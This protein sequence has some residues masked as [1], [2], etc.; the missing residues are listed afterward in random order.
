M[1]SVKG[2]SLEAYI[3]EGQFY[4]NDMELGQPYL[5][6]NALNIRKPIIRIANWNG[7]GPTATITEEPVERTVPSAPED[8]IP[9]LV[10]SLGVDI[11][12]GELL[13]SGGQFVLHN[14][15]KEPVRALPADQL[16]LKH[17]NLYDIQVEIDSFRLDRDTFSGRVNWIAAKDESGF[18]L[19]R[20]SAREAVVSP[21]EL[22][23]NGLSI[24]TPTTSLGDSLRFTYNGFDDWASFEDKV[25]MDA[26][27][28]DA[29]VTLQ[30][31]IA[32]VP[33]LN[34]NPFFN[35]NR[36]TNLQIE[37]RVRGK[38][39]NLR[40]NDLNITLAD[41]THL[42]GSFSSQNLAVPE[43][44]F[45]IL[46]LDQLN[47]RLG[48]LRQLIPNFNP[49][50]NFNKLGRL[51]FSGSFVGFFVD[52]VAKGQLQTDLGDAA[53]DMQMVLTEGAERARYSGNLNLTDFDL[54]GWSG[55]PDF[56]LVDFSSEVA[57]GYGL[58]EN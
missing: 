56:G 27:F 54:G 33:K 14:Y 49:P 21:K 46:E 45:L 50:S 13:L 8:I 4:L 12:V 36:D 20:L 51:Q 10:D 26:R 31:I 38:V 53:M 43:E 3:T 52:F 47:T 32:F 34:Q 7:S 48:T 35:S 25:R 11:R 2:S 22:T 30:D 15:R 28:H 9:D 37:G 41:G 39:N 18:Q 23:L 58:T 29:D 1:D 42:E 24:I 44:E 17:L 57:D 55:N 19:E 6:V 40:G 5:D 16:D